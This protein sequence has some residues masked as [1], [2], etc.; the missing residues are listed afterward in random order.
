MAVDEAIR[1]AKEYVQKL[2][3]GSDYR[4]EEVTHEDDDSFAITVSFRPA[5]SVTDAVLAV[6]ADPGAARRGRWT[7]GIDA[8][9]AYK[10]VSVA[11][12]GHVRGVRIRPIVVG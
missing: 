11:A 5:D 4:L 10:V 9:R 6:P 7:L 3:A 2:F 1:V 8:S 12:D